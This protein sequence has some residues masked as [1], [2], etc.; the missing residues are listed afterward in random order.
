VI[1]PDKVVAMMVKAGISPDGQLRGYRTTIKSSH[2]DMD[3][4]VRATMSGIIGSIL[5]SCRVFISANTVHQ[6][7]PGG[8]LC[9]CIVRTS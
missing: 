8:G 5:G 6:A 7:P 4:H 3:K 1:N 9:A 2:L